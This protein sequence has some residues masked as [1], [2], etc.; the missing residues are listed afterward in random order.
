MAI[1]EFLTNID[2]EFSVFINSLHSG[3]LDVAMV[4]ISK[5]F[6]WIPLYVFLFILLV[7]RYRKNSWILALGIILLILL[8]DQS[9]TH[10]FK[11]VFQRLRPCHNEDINAFLNLPAGCSK[12]YPY[13]F[14][15]AHSA[16]S[17][18]LA[19]FVAYFMKGK[20]FN[21]MYLWAALVGYS[22]IYLAAHYFGDVLCGAI[23]GILIAL[24]VIM[25]CNKA[26]RFFEKRTT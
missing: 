13:G 19:A 23:W 8:V 14:I 15:S 11:D 1:L 3:W 25:L 2:V 5:K 22:R 7:R 20:W 21:L 9:C 17:F 6:F 16:N 18:A 10:L 24:C 4:W 12:R 26:L